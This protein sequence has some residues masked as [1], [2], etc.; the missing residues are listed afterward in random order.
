MH[1]L[2]F[3][4]D[5]TLIT[6]HGMGRLALERAF[7]EVFLVDAVGRP[8]L[9]RVR[10]NGRTDPLIIRDLGCVLGVD[11]M[12]FESHR[13]EFEE[14]FLRNLV[15]TVAESPDK[16]P[17]PGVVELLESLHGRPDVQLGLLT[18]NMEQGARIKLEPFGLNRFFPFG[19]FGYDGPDRAAVAARARE[20][21]EQ[22]LGRTLPPSRFL[23]IGDTVHDVQAGRAHGFR[24]VAV[25]TGGE[26]RDDLLSAEPDAVFR[27][28]SPD[29]GFPAWLDELTAGAA[30]GE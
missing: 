30:V 29:H 18:G 19:G 7:E 8:E 22:H 26:R 12:R 10:F 4:I 27:D 28:L 6:G 5:G 14:C 17:C 20:R 15:R 11:D 21:A 23:V 2:L 3:D 9:R 25:E 1:V 24:T 16:S 13:E